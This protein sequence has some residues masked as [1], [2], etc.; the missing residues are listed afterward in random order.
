MNVGDTVDYNGKLSKQEP[1]KN[2]IIKKIELAGDIF[3]QDMAVLDK[4]EGWVSLRE[5]T[6]GAYIIV[7]H[8]PTGRA[9]SM[10]RNYGVLNSDLGIIDIPTEYVEDW[11]GWLTIQAP[12]WVHEMGKL[13]EINQNFH[14]YWLY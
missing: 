1:Q 5:L 8:T 4:V 12:A 9:F 7:I 10:T 2:C 11:S 13:D 14:A 3:N 6:K